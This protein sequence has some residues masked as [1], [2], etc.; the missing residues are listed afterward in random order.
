MKKLGLVVMQAFVPS[1]VPL[2]G[3]RSAT[4]SFLRCHS[5]ADGL[6]MDE[7]EAEE[8]LG[9]VDNPFWVMRVIGAALPLPA[10]ERSMSDQT[11]LC[12][13]RIPPV[14]RGDR[15]RFVWCSQG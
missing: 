12:V 8:L 11:H 13:L 2:L 4:H 10:G 14:T 7:D 3:F 15:W 5:M 1:S 6:G 9:M